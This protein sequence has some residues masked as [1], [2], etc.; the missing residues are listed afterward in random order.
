MNPKKMASVIIASRKPDGK[1][2]TEGEEG[3]ENAGLVSAAEDLLRA[4]ATKDATAVAQALQS[5]FE[6]CDSQPHEEGEHTEEEGME[7]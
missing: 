6:I 1:I 3:E 2:E 4:I 7:S 5:A